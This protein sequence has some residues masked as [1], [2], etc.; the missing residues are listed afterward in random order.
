MQLCWTCKNLCCL[1]GVIHVGGLIIKKYLFVE[2]EA[3]PLDNS[4]KEANGEAS[5]ELVE[6]FQKREELIVECANLEE[7]LE[8]N[9]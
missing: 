3:F 4:I 8:K 7:L 2:S 9:Y 5:P 6:A 1:H